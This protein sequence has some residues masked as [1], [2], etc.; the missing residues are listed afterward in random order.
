MTLSP[1][2]LR[3]GIALYIVDL[4]YLHR[5]ITVN[6]M[7]FLLTIYQTYSKVTDTYDIV[8]QLNAALEAVGVALADGGT[9]LVEFDGSLPT[10][11]KTSSLPHEIG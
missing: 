4:S 7:M 9:E 11:V 10:Q 2:G 3:C 6:L 1:I 5:S 8:V